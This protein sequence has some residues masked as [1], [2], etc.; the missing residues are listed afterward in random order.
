MQTLEKTYILEEEEDIIPK[1]FLGTKINWK[2]SKVDPTVEAVS[3]HR[4][5]FLSLSRPEPP[6]CA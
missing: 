5:P 1:K 2:D 4:A 3:D 6:P